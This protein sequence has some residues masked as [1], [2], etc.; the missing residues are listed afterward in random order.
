MHCYNTSLAKARGGKKLAKQRK[1][2]R[3]DGFQAKGKRK[4][5]GPCPFCLFLPVLV[6][7][8]CH[9][10][11]PQIWWL[12]ATQIHLWAPEIRSL[13]GV[14]RGYHQSAS[15]AAFLLEVLVDNSFPWLVIFTQ[16][17]KPSDLSF[18]SYFFSDSHSPASLFHLWGLL[19]L[20]WTPQIIQGY[21]PISRSLT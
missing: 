7:Y 8:C 11:L 20:H 2:M 21:L 10:K 6:F 5:A 3:R 13:T 12:K 14:S 17:S 15:W 1:G 16:Q 19:W 9:R 18:C 4:K